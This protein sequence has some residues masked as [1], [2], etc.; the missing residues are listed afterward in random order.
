MNEYY[1][2]LQINWEFKQKKKE[3]DDI[4]VIRHRAT[5]DQAAAG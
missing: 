5:T 1:Y 2:M 3:A 4:V